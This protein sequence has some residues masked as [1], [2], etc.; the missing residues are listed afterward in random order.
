MYHC[1]RDILERV[2]E[3]PTWFDD[4]GVPRFCEFAP[5]QLG[6]IHAREA[7][8]AEVSCQFCGRLFRVTLSDAFARAPYSLG[9]DIRL[10]RVRYGDPPNVGC[11]DVGASMGS[12]MHEVLEY[13][14][15]DIEISHEWRRDPMLEGLVPDL[16]LRPADAVAEVLAVCDAGAKT[17]LII[18]T[19]HRNRY[20]LLGRT[21]AACAAGGRVIVT[22]ADNRT[23]N[24]M[25]GPL[26][27]RAVADANI[28]GQVTM[29]DY[30]QAAELSPT[31]GDR[32]VML[33]APTPRT[34]AMRS[35]WSEAAARLATTSAG[36]VRIELVLAHSRPML[37]RP[38]AV[39]DAA[40]VVG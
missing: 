19:S 28:D 37:E 8:L 38:D 20:H 23:S 2:P 32:F 22:Y 39:V 16:E 12:I 6:N 11:C 29:A 24:I 35:A 27:S 31:P 36:K 17:V 40:R 13:W 21:A 3:P 10:A 1:Y 33:A 4:H 30:L 7:A 14:S 34:D 18:C 15:R 9:D 25:P 26:V 5:D